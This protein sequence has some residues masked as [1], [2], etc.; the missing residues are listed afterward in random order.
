MGVGKGRAN[1]KSRKTKDRH[2]TSP[3]RARQER[4]APAQ[5]SWRRKARGEQIKKEGDQRKVSAKKKYVRREKISLISKDNRVKR[6]TVE[7][8]NK[9]RGS[10]GSAY[11]CGDFL[12]A[13]AKQKKKSA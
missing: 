8:A 4:V 12:R 11:V 10:G 9:A 6:T 5:Q 13:E 7:L 3:K 2:T 1:Q